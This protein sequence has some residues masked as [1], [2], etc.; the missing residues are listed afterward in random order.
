MITEIKKGLQ[1]RHIWLNP[2]HMTLL[3]FLE[4]DFE[5]S[6]ADNQNTHSISYFSVPL[7]LKDKSVLQLPRHLSVQW[8][9][10]NNV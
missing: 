10:K 7:R 3:S 1:M 6:S 8:R 9:F 2:C 5:N 4:T